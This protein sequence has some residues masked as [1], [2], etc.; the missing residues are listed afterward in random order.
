MIQKRRQQKEKRCGQIARFPWIRHLSRILALELCH[1]LSCDLR[2]PKTKLF[3]SDFK[4][5]HE[6]GI[7]WKRKTL[8]Y[9]FQL[10]SETKSQNGC[11]LK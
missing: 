9:I 3:Q 4:P 2:R 7:T 6:N 11:F 5:F 1:D 8:K 10:V